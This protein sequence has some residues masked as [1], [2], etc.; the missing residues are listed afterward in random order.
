MARPG[1][2]LTGVNILAGELDVKRLEILHEAVPAAKRIGAL[3][4]PD[5]GFDILP[6]LDAAARQL[7]LELVVVTVRS[8]DELTGSL[9]ALQ[10]AGVDAVNVL[11]SAAISPARASIIDRFN[12]AR[13]PAIYE[14]PEIAESG[15]FLGYG[16]ASIFPHDLSPASPP[17]SCAGPGPKTCQSSSRI[18]LIW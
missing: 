17:K 14:A 9:D 10:S 15:G 4:L 1:G 18:D 3:A 13:L 8:L 7:D 2:N 12:R 5:R 16:A 11:A 6:E